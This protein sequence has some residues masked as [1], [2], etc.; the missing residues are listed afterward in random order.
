MQLSFSDLGQA[1][2][3]ETFTTLV[4]KPL[5]HG[6]WVDYAPGWLRAPHSVFTTMR[7]AAR[8]Q[9]H[10]RPMYQRVVVVPRLIAARPGTGAPLN[11]DDSE[12]EVMPSRAS[13]EAVAAA[14][15]QLLD[16][17]RLLSRRYRRDLS[18]IS[19]AWYR[20]GNDSVA[21]HGDKLGALR[22]DTVVAIASVGARRSFLLRKAGGGRSLTFQVGE[23]DLLVMGGSCQETFEHAVPKVAYAGPRIA[24]MFRECSPPAIKPP[25]VEVPIAAKL[26][27]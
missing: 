16:L 10:R 11:W 25:R 6:A 7:L 2:A 13:P 20:D 17:S 1:G 4:H 26:N 9:Q 27:A 15:Q 5:G 18:H 14:E 21:F 3:D 23:G 22:R 8:W 19:L 12:I 24:L